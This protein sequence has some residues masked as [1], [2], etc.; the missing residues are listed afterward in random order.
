MKERNRYAGTVA[1]TVAVQ[2]FA[3]AV[4]LCIYA[5]IAG[6]VFYSLSEGTGRV[7]ALSV[8]GAVAAGLVIVNVLCVI[9][10]RKVYI[11]RPDSIAIRDSEEIV[12][13]AYTTARPVLI[14]KTTW[15][16]ICLAITPLVYIIFLQG[17]FLHQ[18]AQ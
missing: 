16:I 4:Y 18:A 1:C 14:H 5:L 8:C 11:T 6:G 3:L 7:I 17:Y 9:K 10:G 2:L 15:S 12:R 13:L